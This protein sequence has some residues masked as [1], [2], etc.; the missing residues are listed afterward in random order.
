MVFESFRQTQF[1]TITIFDDQIVEGDE[2]FE[3]SLVTQPQLEGAVFSSQPALVTILEN[4]CKSSHL[5]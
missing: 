2:T 4:D 3:A 1:V 5:Q